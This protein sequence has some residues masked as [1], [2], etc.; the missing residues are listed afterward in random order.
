MSETKAATLRARDMM[1]IEYL[2]IRDGYVLRFSQGQTALAI[3]L[4]RNSSAKS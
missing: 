3:G 4:L 2:F 1:T